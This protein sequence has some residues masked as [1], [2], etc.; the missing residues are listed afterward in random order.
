MD[1]ED[2]NVD[3]VAKDIGEL[4]RETPPP[5]SAC[6]QQR[7]SAGTQ[8]SSRTTHYTWH[9]FLEIRMQGQCVRTAAGIIEEVLCLGRRYASLYRAGIESLAA[10][11]GAQTPAKDGHEEMAEWHRNASC[12]RTTAASDVPSLVLLLPS[13]ASRPPPP[14][15][16]FR[17]AHLSRTCY[18]ILSYPD[19]CLEAM[20]GIVPGRARAW[21]K[22]TEDMADATSSSLGRTQSRG[23]GCCYQC[24]RF[25]TPRCSRSRSGALNPN[26]P[27]LTQ[28]SS[29]IEGHRARNVVPGHEQQRQRL[30]FDLPR[31]RAVALVLDLGW[32]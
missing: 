15:P 32:A 28:P 21:W 4:G 22:Y 29:R 20:L 13:Y 30:P 12:A 24:L 27:S 6:V 23:C 10:G 7:M 1:V 2:A 19:A 14:L 8:H 5:P 26:Y 18:S 11:E 31:A 3:E 25:G 17:L 9:A 16:S